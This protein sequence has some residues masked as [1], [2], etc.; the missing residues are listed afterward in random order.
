MA[1]PLE[2][3]AA[4]T[5]EQNDLTCDA[6]ERTGFQALPSCNLLGCLG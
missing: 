1:V 6:L 2:H 4:E 5:H 3:C